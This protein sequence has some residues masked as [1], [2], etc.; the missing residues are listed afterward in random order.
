MTAG[1]QS[2]MLDLCATV[3]S[4]APPV[5]AMKSGQNSGN[6][7]QELQAALEHEDARCISVA[8]RRMISDRLHSGFDP[9]LQWLR[10]NPGIAEADAERLS[11]YAAGLCESQPLPGFVLSVCAAVAW[12][13]R[14][15]SSLYELQYPGIPYAGWPKLAEN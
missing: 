11:D 12:T 3:I 7:E 15:G 10:E 2:L 9:V 4:D 14:A 13:A 8:V 5:P 6:W 1:G